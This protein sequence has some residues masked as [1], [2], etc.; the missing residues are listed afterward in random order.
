MA[1]CLCLLR[2][3]RPGSGDGYGLWTNAVP[4]IT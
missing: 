1:I 3:E 2:W 4:E